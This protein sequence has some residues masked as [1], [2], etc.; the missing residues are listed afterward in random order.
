MAQKGVL[1]LA[2]EAGVPIIPVAVAAHP[3]IVFKTWDRFELP[4]PFSRM[5]LRVGEPLRV[6]PAARGPA[7]ESWRRLLETR[8][9]DL[10]QQSRG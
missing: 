1:Y 2:R 4:L 8:L 3:K 6:P 5:I 9:N 7:L 10:S